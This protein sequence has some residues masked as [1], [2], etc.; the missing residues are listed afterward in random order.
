[1]I[2]KLKSTWKRSK[3]NTLYYKQIG[4]YVYR[5]SPRTKYIMSRFKSLDEVKIFMVNH[6][7]KEVKQH[8][9]LSEVE[10]L[11]KVCD[12]FKE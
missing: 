9:K 3:F 8:K 1:M 12:N 7:Y 4:I 5:R 10:W 6:G 2:L 11:D